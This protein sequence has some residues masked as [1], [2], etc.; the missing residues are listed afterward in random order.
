MTF[1]QSE[2]KCPLLGCPFS[3]AGRC[4]RGF[5]FFELWEYAAWPFDTIL[6]ILRC[7]S[8]AQSLLKSRNALIWRK[9][10]PTDMRLSGTARLITIKFV[11]WMWAKKEANLSLAR[12]R[13]NRSRRC[14]LGRCGTCAKNSSAKKTPKSS[15]TLRAR[16][17]LLRKTKVKTLTMAADQSH[18]WYQFIIRPCDLGLIILLKKTNLNSA[19]Y[20]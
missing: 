7:L 3:G 4:I 6:D 9:W 16:S 10:E 2:A 14:P 8:L 18:S 15:L 11:M 5:G 13:R 12:F 1:S 20:A 19:D 17:K